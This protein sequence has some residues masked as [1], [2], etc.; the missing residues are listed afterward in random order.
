MEYAIIACVVAVL[1]GTIS[2]LGAYIWGGTWRLRASE[3]G[4]TMLDQQK[5]I[6]ALQASNV[7]IEGQRVD[8][9]GRRNAIIA[10]LRAEVSSLEKDVEACSD[11]AAVRT[12]LQALL[13]STEAAAFAAGSLPPIAAPATGNPPAAKP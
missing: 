10:A 5:Q 6:A 11:P 4:Q 9:V 8:D 7:I 3:Y 1:A 2:T 13:G 12:R